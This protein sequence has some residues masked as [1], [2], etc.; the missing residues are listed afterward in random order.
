M[1]KQRVAAAAGFASRPAEA[2][3]LVSFYR[4]IPGARAPQRADR[5]AGGTLPTRAYRYCEPSAAASA[6][7]WYVFPPISFSLMWNGSDVIWTYEGAK[8]WY[9]LGVAQFPGFSRHFDRHAPPGV[10]SFAPP[11]LGAATNPGIVQLW[12]GVVARTGPGWSLLVRP[13]A[14]LA[15]SRGF[16]LYEGLI[17]TDRWFGPLITNLR[18]TQTDVPIEIRKDY[19]LVQVQPVPRFAYANETLASFEVIEDLSGFTA[20]DWQRYRETVVHPNVDPNRR[21]GRYAA[22]SRRQ[23]KKR[24]PVHHLAKK[25]PFDTSSD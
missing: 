18:L 9:P 19:P 16:E 23:E 15:R 1:S 4:L 8:S 5:S 2:E 13:P 11:F 12:T 21:R 10:K 7:G 24:C 17:E 3:P 6:Y 25:R 14:N 22:A 20:A